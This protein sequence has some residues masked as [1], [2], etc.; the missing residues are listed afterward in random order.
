MRLVVLDVNETLFGL[1]PVASAFASVG[2]DPA[3]LELWFAR[4]LRDGFAVALIGRLATF[5]D[6]ARHHVRVLAEQRGLV[7]DD[8]AVE[9]VVAGFGQVEPHPDVPAGLRR[10]RAADVTVVALTNGTVGVTRGFLERA[11]LDAL[12][13]RVVDVTTAGRWKPAPEPYREVLATADVP[14]G[15]AA[16]VAAHPWDVAGAMAVGMAGGYV[17]RHDVSWPPFLDP[18]TVRGPRLDTVVDALLAGGA[19]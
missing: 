1:D 19:A 4:V 9:E 10:A 6:L 5:P 13:D 2:L 7:L 15:E 8:A 14:A 12:V 11:G 16:M 17:D 3:H 18:P